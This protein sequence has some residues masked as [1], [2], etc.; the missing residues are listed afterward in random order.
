MNRLVTCDLGGIPLPYQ[1]PFWLDP[2]WEKRKSFPLLIPSW[3]SIASR[4]NTFVYT[5]ILMDLVVQSTASRY[6]ANH[7]D[8]RVLEV[9]KGQ[10]KGQQRETLALMPC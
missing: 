8:H 3:S 6:L 4:V 10:Q 7:E 2:A 1:R 5:L 9:G